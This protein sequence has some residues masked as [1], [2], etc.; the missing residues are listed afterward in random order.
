L[1]I[2]FNVLVDMTASGIHN[3]YDLVLVCEVLQTIV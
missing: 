2:L 3:K 1:F